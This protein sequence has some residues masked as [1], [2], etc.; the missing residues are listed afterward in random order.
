MQ[1]D[2]DYLADLI[3]YS[4]QPSLK[5]KIIE[6]LDSIL[7]PGENN[8]TNQLIDKKIGQPFYKSL[9]MI[10]VAMLLTALFLIPASSPFAFLGLEAFGIFIT[11]T[12]AYL[13]GV[14]SL[15]F[16]G[17]YFWQKV[18]QDADLSPKP[19]LANSFIFFGA[20]LATFIYHGYFRFLEYGHTQDFFTPAVFAACYYDAITRIRDF[21]FTG[22]RNLIRGIHRSALN[23]KNA[24]IIAVTGMAYGTGEE[25][26]QFFHWSTV[27]EYRKVDGSFDSIDL[28]ASALG[29]AAVLW[30]IRDYYKNKR[31]SNLSLVMDFI[32]Q[33]TLG[34]GVLKLPDDVSEL[35]D[36]D[37]DKR[38]LSDEDIII[39][40]HVIYRETR[41]KDIR[42]D[43]FKDYNNTLEKMLE[44]V[45]EYKYGNGKLTKKDVRNKFSELKNELKRR[46]TSGK[47]DRGID[48]SLQQQSGASLELPATKARADRLGLTGFW[49]NLFVGH[50]EFFPSLSK[51]F[52]AEHVRSTPENEKWRKGGNIAIK[53][54]AA[55]GAVLGGFAAVFYLIPLMA[56]LVPFVWFPALIA[57]KQLTIVM[58]T[59]AGAYLLN[60]PTH[61]IYNSIAPK[62][63]ELK[64]PETVSQISRP[65]L[66]LPVGSD[67][68]TTGDIEKALKYS[69]GELK[70]TLIE[71]KLEGVAKED[72]TY[73]E[74]ELPKELQNELL[75]EGAQA[76]LDG[77]VYIAVPVGGAGSGMSRQLMPQD[78]KDM[79]NGR[80]ILSKAAVPVGKYKGKPVT[81]MDLFAG[82]A[83]K[84]ILEID[85]AAKKAGKKSNALN[86]V[87]A[88]M[89]N[90][91]YEGELKRIFEDV[92]YYGLNRSSVRSFI[93]PLGIK[94][95]AIPEEVR[96]MKQKDG[97]TSEKDKDEYYARL[98]YAADR[99]A[100][101]LS[102][103]DR[104]AVFEN[105]KV[106]LGQGEFFHRLIT[107]KELLFM[108][109][110]GIKYITFNGKIDNCAAKF[111]EAY[112]KLLGL[113]ALKARDEG[114]G[115]QAEVSK[116]IDGD[117][118]G[119]WAV[120]K[121]GSFVDMEQSSVPGGSLESFAYNNGFGYFT[122]EYI[123]GLYM[124]D[125]QSLQGFI[126]EY[127]AAA[128]NDEKLKEIAERGI[129]RF[130][131][132]VDAKPANS[133][134]ETIITR[135]YLE[136]I[137]SLLTEEELQALENMAASGKAVSFTPMTAHEETNVWQSSLIKN[138]ANKKISLVGV[139]GGRNI[140]IVK[141]QD[142]DWKEKRKI[143]P[144]LR[145]LSTRQWDTSEGGKLKALQKLNKSLG[146]KEGEEG[147]ISDLDDPRLLI[148]LKSYAGNKIITEDLLKY[149]YEQNAID[150][151]MF[152]ENAD[153]TEFAE[154]AAAGNAVMGNALNAAVAPASSFFDSV[155]EIIAKLIL[156]YYY[157]ADKLPAI[158]KN[159]LFF[160]NVDLSRN[161]LS[162]FTHDEAFKKIA[163]DGFDTVVFRSLEKNPGSHV[164]MRSV[165]EQAHKNGVK[166]V[167]EYAADDF[168]SFAADLPKRLS[169]MKIG[170]NAVDGIKLDLSKLS[171]HDQKKAVSGL[172]NIRR[173]LP[174]KAL[175]SIYCD[176]YDR[177]IFDRAKAVRAFKVSHYDHGYL[178][179]VLDMT[180]N[181]WIEFGT[182][183]KS[184]DANLT[185]YGAAEKDVAEIAYA[186]TSGPVGIDFDAVKNMS[187]IRNASEAGVS[188][189][190]NKI[191]GERKK[192][193]FLIPDDD[194]VLTGR[195]SYKYKRDAFE[196]FKNEE[197][198]ANL[199]SI[200]KQI[201][202]FQNALNWKNINE[203]KKKLAALKEFLS[204]LGAW[205][206]PVNRAG[207]IYVIKNGLG[208]KLR[209]AEGVFFTDKS[210]RTLNFNINRSGKFEASKSFADKMAQI[211]QLKV[212]AD[213]DSNIAPAGEKFG[214]DMKEIFSG[215]ALYGIGLPE[216]IT[217]NTKDS[218][219]LRLKELAPEIKE[220]IDFYTDY[221]AKH[222]VWD[223]KSGDFKEDG[224]SADTDISGELRQKIREEVDNADFVFDKLYADFVKNTDGI[225]NY[226]K[227]AFAA[228]ASVNGETL[229]TL[230]K[231]INA[232]N[233]EELIKKWGAFSPD[234]AAAALDKL[235][236][237]YIADADSPSA[238][239][240]YIDILKAAALLEYSRLSFSQF[241]Q[242]SKDKK[243][244]LN[245]KI[246][247][248]IIS[249][250]YEKADRDNEAA[251]HLL[252][253]RV[254]AV[255]TKIA[256][257]Y[258]KKLSKYGLTVLS[259]GRV[260]IDIL[261]ENNKK[262]RVILD[263]LNGGVKSENIL[264]T[265]D[266]MLFE[267]MDE[268]AAGSDDSVAKLAA[269]NEKARGML[270]INTSAE[271]HNAKKRADVI[272]ASEKLSSYGI[273][274]GD[275]TETA[276][277]LH[278]L[279]LDR[280][281]FNIGSIAGDE[282][283]IVEN[284]SE[285]VRTIL[286]DGLPYADGSSLKIIAGEDIERAS[287]KIFTRA[288]Q[289]KYIKETVKSISENY[290]IGK[291]Y[292]AKSMTVGMNNP[293][294]ILRLYTDKGDFIFKALTNN[295]S[296]AQYIVN[297]QK[298]LYDKGLQVPQPVALKTSG[299]LLLEKDGLYYALETAL[300]GNRVRQNYS[301]FKYYKEFATYHA[302]I[303]NIVHS[304]DYKN[305]DGNAPARPA[306]YNMVMQ[307]KEELLKLKSSLS[308]KDP[309]SQTVLDN[310]DFIMGQIA[311]FEN[312]FTKDVQKQM[313]NSA[314]TFDINYNNMFFNEENG[315][316]AG[317]F[318]FGGTSV[319][320]RVLAFDYMFNGIYGSKYYGAFSYK[321]NGYNVIKDALKEYNKIVDI[322]MTPEE[323][324]GMVEIMRGRF[325]YNLAHRRFI[326]R[327]YGGNIFSH[328]ER[329]EYTD[330]II[331]QFKQFSED[332]SAAK[333]DALIND[334]L[335][336]SGQGDGGIDRSLQ[337]QSGASLELPATKAEADRLGLTGFWRNLF[338]GHKEFF[339]SLL[340][341]FRAEHVRSTPEN[342]KWR[343]GGDIAIK[344]AAAIGAVLGGFAAA[345]YLIPLMAPLVPFVW[346]PALIAAKQLTIVLFTLAG[347][348][349]LNVPTHAIYNSIAPK[350]AEL[351]LASGESS[352]LNAQPTETNNNEDLFFD[353][354][355][356]NYAKP[357]WYLLRTAIF[358]SLNPIKF[359]KE[360]KSIRWK[361]R[362]SL[363]LGAIYLP[364][365]VTSAVLMFIHLPAVLSVMWLTVSFMFGAFLKSSV[366]RSVKI[367]DEPTFD[368]LDGLVSKGLIKKPSEEDKKY[369]VM[370]SDAILEDLFEVYSAVSDKEKAEAIKE[371]L[372]L[373]KENAPK[374]DAAYDLLAAAGIQFAHIPHVI[375]TIPQKKMDSFTHAG[376]GLVLTT[377]TKDSFVSGTIDYYK[378]LL[379][380]AHEATH[381]N[382]FV[383]NGNNWEP[384]PWLLE[385]RAR[386]TEI[387]VINALKLW[388]FASQ[389]SR[390]DINEHQRIIDI[391]QAMHDKNDEL[392]QMLADNIGKKSLLYYRG[393]IASGGKQY[394]S[395]YD[396]GSIYRKYWCVLLEDGYLKVYD[397]IGYN[398]VGKQI[399]EI[400]LNIDTKTTESGQ[401]DGV[402]DRKIVNTVEVSAVESK[403]VFLKILE[404]KIA[405]GSTDAVAFFDK[406]YDSF[407]FTHLDSP[408]ILLNGMEAR[409]AG[410]ADS[411]RIIQALK[412]KYATPEENLRILFA[413]KQAAEATKP[414]LSKEPESDKISFQINKHLK[415]AQIMV[416][417]YNYMIGQELEDSAIDE[418][419]L[420][421]KFGLAEG[422]ISQYRILHR[423]MKL[424]FKYLVG[425]LQ[426]SNA[427]LNVRLLAFL[428]LN[429]RTTGYE[430]E[431]ARIAPA[432]AKEFKDA[433]DS[434]T[435]KPPTNDFDLRAAITGIHLFMLAES[436][437]VSSI[438]NGN[439]RN[440]YLR[441]SEAGFF[442]SSGLVA[443]NSF[444]FFSKNHTSVF[445][446]TAH[447]LGHNYF[448]EASP[449][450]DVRITASQAS[451][452][453][454]IAA[455][456]AMG[457]FR[458]DIVISRKA[459]LKTFMFD[460]EKSE[461]DEEHNA[462]EGFLEITQN[463]FEKVLK[464]TGIKL[465][466]ETLFSV[467]LSFGAKYQEKVS[468]AVMLRSL[469][470]EY[471]KAVSKETNG[472][473]SETLLIDMYRSIEQQIQK[474]GQGD[475]VIDRS[476]QQPASLEL[477]ATKA[478]A[479]KL[480][481]NN[482]EAQ[483]ERMLAGL[484]DKVA[485]GIANEL[486]VS[487]TFKADF[488]NLFS[489]DLFGNKYTP[490]ER[491]DFINKH[492]N[493]L[494]GSIVEN[495]DLK[496]GLLAFSF[497]AKNNAMDT[498]NS[499]RTA[500]LI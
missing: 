494:L 437:T 183:A 410:N 390:L 181:V 248:D 417:N 105:E 304:E 112:L 309:A 265:G 295:K 111:D 327:N 454:E 27:S 363:E 324:K 233:V 115:F 194:F 49:R 341:G 47:R 401:V 450:I 92:D 59:L 142:M 310:F 220:N 303:D 291:I 35:E 262:S 415:D 315:N 411:R 268:D 386:Q 375:T 442:P 408:Q 428:Y 247:E 63:A 470:D 160:T 481:I 356:T 259:S 278:K 435:F 255:K 293:S 121:D 132:L 422:E 9:W 217:G 213:M 170:S 114:V 70:T 107:S 52:R 333:I 360:Q 58:F 323:L 26:A 420:K 18:N 131:K 372:K 225:D 113:F 416:D 64:L 451:L 28:W 321:Y 335:G 344:T 125:G 119:V 129:E 456:T 464:S 185:D 354:M 76:L 477:P 77:S 195:N 358:A 103:D 382:E 14:I 473:I 36:N 151:D 130:Q 208:A 40:K 43:I 106:P 212:F 207:M 484:N 20:G 15:V 7:N 448:Y 127:R 430:T 88:Y 158:N 277:H 379:L 98:A 374:I 1:K 22:H 156:K 188:G 423:A 381:Y 57:A 23:I 472:L 201:I 353:D 178:Q 118:G 232:G 370:F 438:M 492:V 31:F 253:I 260:A 426:D 443:A 196:Y 387:K 361:I 173:L 192:L 263:V 452:L 342:E 402:I 80:D 460:I 171:K 392:K 465:S 463:V 168:D 478:R 75:L 403:E 45:K 395:I 287:G 152:A 186:K 434:N 275:S 136:R 409:Y 203:D 180:D 32:E 82:G 475:M 393:F 79:L 316:A 222:W 337:Q 388:A 216:V 231:T 120:R 215:L 48:H 164:F 406:W 266:E 210:G 400:N 330:D 234:E 145:Y 244:V 345:F 331:K 54:A 298:P 407:K 174:E 140:D 399:G 124:K 283:F 413:E 205:D 144:W 161:D 148:S 419:I 376:E 198:R 60:V 249:G 338:A 348:Y 469:L 288:D 339:P 258:G 271:P 280:L 189:L 329:A 86:N 444:F 285:A 246:R 445:V 296:S 471:V 25:I 66:L 383:D 206:N 319:A 368:V 466:Y 334:V 200:R 33:K 340:K 72:V 2:V 93:Q 19:L 479:D 453:H 357:A 122:P 483:R 273:N 322:K 78:V 385:I 209:A 169:E 138:R 34:F 51:G 5:I 155:L 436:K 314:S 12:P 239:K 301:D 39:M 137:K 117:S 56:P 261:K 236:Q 134:T 439:E 143:L 468:Q 352:S 457:L 95:A 162:Y 141:Y 13:A 313:I 157:K 294:M 312:R 46:M 182:D 378:L 384:E 187:Q 4:K 199:N 292:S 227:T 476:L 91:E 108:F 241:P 30:V 101:V 65:A 24:V 350:G 449:T 432:L 254:S 482:P 377:L 242:D 371:I 272:D 391:F 240:A 10:P 99:R 269:D 71:E 211:A 224:R 458:N 380:L 44:T 69:S 16:L 176:Y 237:L 433:I 226:E 398:E 68:L 83:A 364:L 159:P 264:Y 230:F 270:V 431:I 50:K 459:K 486:G 123:A 300:Y 128:N 41:R 204:S 488:S 362:A 440:L 163:A 461:Q 425:V 396:L 397:G 116:K 455:Y 427:G 184:Y 325:I 154:N 135:E 197:I 219:D 256:R 308:G 447:E 100:R 89:G 326:D 290:D 318:D 317:M 343:K 166:V 441:I 110:N 97:F 221:G 286:T 109:D 498:E 179:D 474:S 346:F 177:E 84:L 418:N 104:A 94:F 487:N 489:D 146:F 37:N 150:P 6:L 281:E 167:V 102:G 175:L 490:D 359:I 191:A 21:L 235:E 369:T 495:K 96:K 55:I 90:P 355:L 193:E 257:F 284:L 267:G 238:E 347:A 245:K 373:S 228:I 485:D 414:D 81:Y 462:A 394:V 17:K 53:T 496:N 480:A 73:V 147:Y 336:Q 202:Y 421:E 139:N 424:D 87:V 389:D 405:A 190:L 62:G 299:D 214:A 365:V 133:K 493:E 328:P 500:T 172:E 276:M 251:V 306:V 165:I 297:F 497:N 42:E 38:S 499:I 67:G 302:L 307:T 289:I 153:N 467:I 332:F 3:K 85:R 61:A 243:V 349:L 274:T 8:I 29:T 229:Q 367:Y 366:K 223:A 404:G 11:G 250:A 252:P 311:V 320:P 279:L 218:V 305:D 126:E 412:A 491:E 446:N 282:H 149:I 74:E 351:E 429:R